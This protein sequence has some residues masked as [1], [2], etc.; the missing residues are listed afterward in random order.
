M[1][2]YM[3]TAYEK[4]KEEKILKSMKN[5]GCTREE[6]EDIFRCDEIIDKGG[7]TEYDL[8]I[9]KEKEI[10]KIYA[11]NDRRAK[12]KENNQRGKVRAENTTKSGIIA[13][14]AEFLTK[15]GEIACE[16]VKITNKERQIAFHC[17]END[18]ELTLVQKR[19]PK[20]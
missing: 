11:V 19:K 10:R 3:A 7:R 8:P 17:G 4:R 15:N 1:I 13:E 12:D 14:L 5:L 20:N 9:E 18:Y 2:H 16:N 6:A